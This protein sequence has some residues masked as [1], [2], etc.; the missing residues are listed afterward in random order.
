M[1]CDDGLS[2]PKRSGNSQPFD[3]APE[4]ARRSVPAVTRAGHFDIDWRNVG[5]WVAY[6]IG[7]IAIS[8]GI[9]VIMVVITQEIH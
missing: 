9:V 1:S 2:R 3:Q 6:F 8:L 4:L 5:F 7:A